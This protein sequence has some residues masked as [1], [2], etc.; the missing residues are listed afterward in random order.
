MKL[1][2]ILAPMVA[3]RVPHEVLLET[4]RAYEDN[5]AAL[6]AALVPPGQR[7]RSRQWLK[8]R[9]RVLERDNCTCTYCGAWAGTVDHVVPIALG[10]SND[11]SNLAACCA[12]CNR[13]KGAK[14]LTEWRHMQ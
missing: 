1:S 3:A 11:D 8:I 5:R 7:L 12:Y 4:V 13:S 10:G 9:A 14:P 2:A 6:I